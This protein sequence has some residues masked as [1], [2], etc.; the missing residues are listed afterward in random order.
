MI[1][2]PWACNISSA[3]DSDLASIVPERSSPEESRVM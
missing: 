3:S 1:G 2:I